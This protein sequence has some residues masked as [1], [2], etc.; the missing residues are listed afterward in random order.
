MIY[1]YFRKIAFLYTSLKK[2][3]VFPIFTPN[4]LNYI[5]VE[6]PHTV[7]VSMRPAGKISIAI[8]Y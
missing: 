6:Q 7:W 2:G 8:Q 4:S 3:K 1:C 5:P